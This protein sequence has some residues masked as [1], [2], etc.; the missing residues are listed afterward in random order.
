MSESPTENPR[1]KLL[2]WLSGGGWFAIVAVLLVG[3]LAVRLFFPPVPAFTEDGPQV[4]F[5]WTVADARTGE[6]IDLSDYRG[7]VVVLNFWATWCPPCRV[8]KPAINR[9]HQDMEDEGLKVLAVSLQESPQTVVDY[10]DSHGYEL[11]T[12]IVSGAP[13]SPLDVSV[14]PTTYVINRR[15]EVVLKQVG[16]YTGWDSKGMKSNLRELLNS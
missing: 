10:L 4:D 8:E 3:F 16:A 14:V 12:A 2:A 13:P 5:R 11:R 6:L 9:L 1:N 15:G 7:E